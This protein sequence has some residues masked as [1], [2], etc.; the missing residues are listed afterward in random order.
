MPR[1]NEKEFRRQ[2]LGFPVSAVV[3][4]SSQESHELTGVGGS[5]AHDSVLLP[6][7]TL[8]VG[9]HEVSLK[10]AHVLVKQSSDTSSWAAGNLGMDLLNQAQ[11]VTFD[12][13][14]M[15]LRLE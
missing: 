11:T 4:L 9:G 12:F 13:H 7:V 8:K 3:I 10:P 1:T 2:R 15:T 5:S 6:S 14:A